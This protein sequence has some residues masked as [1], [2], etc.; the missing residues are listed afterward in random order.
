M[1]NYYYTET[2]SLHSFAKAKPLKAKDLTA[3]KREATKNQMFLSTT[4]KI[5]IEEDIG[6]GDL[7]VDHVAY[8]EYGKKWV[9]TIST[10]QYR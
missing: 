5:G 6:R 3:A 7:L 2:D 4:L 9:D 1:A 8:K 10:K